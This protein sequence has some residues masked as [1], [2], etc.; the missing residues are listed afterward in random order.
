MVNRLRPKLGMSLLDKNIT[1]II[2]HRFTNERYV[3][4]TI[5]VFILQIYVYF[6]INVQKPPK[7]GS[8][9]KEKVLNS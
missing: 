7:K 6:L 9:N 5:C 1:S 8:N 4:N 3:Y 2:F